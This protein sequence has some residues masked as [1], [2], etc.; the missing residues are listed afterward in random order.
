MSRASVSDI[1]RRI[2]QLR[3]QKQELLQRERQKERKARTHRLIERGALLEKYCEV[4]DW[5]TP[6][7]ETMLSYIISLPQI[8]DYLAE[9]HHGVNISADIDMED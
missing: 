7:V 4:S 5:D 6:Q 3:R 8:R 9:H 2:E 1:D